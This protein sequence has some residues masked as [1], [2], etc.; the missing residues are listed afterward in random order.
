M[1]EEIGGILVDPVGAGAL[2][3]VLPVP[4]REKT[5]P[6]AAILRKT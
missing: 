5:D 6:Q 3:F 2:E 4:A 1:L